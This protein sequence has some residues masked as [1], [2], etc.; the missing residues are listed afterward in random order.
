[1]FYRSFYQDCTILLSKTLQ[2]TVYLAQ[3]LCHWY[4]YEQR[5][6]IS[7]PSVELSSYYS[8]NLFDSKNDIA[9][10]E[11]MEIGAIYSR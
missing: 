1:M 11:K 2:E 5:I 6:E 9:Q 10:N 3:I 4:K 7:V 8:R